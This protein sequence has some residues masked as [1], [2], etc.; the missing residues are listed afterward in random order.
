MKEARQGRVY[1]TLFHLYA[2]VE[3]EK[4]IHRSV[5][6]WGKERRMTTKRQEGTF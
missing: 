2:I 4:L 5:V 3:Q 1:T 6:A